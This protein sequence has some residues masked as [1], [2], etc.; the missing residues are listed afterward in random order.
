M[1]CGNI[2]LFFGSL[3][4]GVTLRYVISLVLIVSEPGPVFPDVRVEK[5]KINFFLTWRKKKGNRNCVW[6]DTYL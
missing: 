6:S 5:E 1:G 3:L 4:H 2:T